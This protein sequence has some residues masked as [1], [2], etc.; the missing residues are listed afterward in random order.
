[1]PTKCIDQMP[2]PIAKAPVWLSETPGGI[3]HRPPTLGEHTD[4]IMVELGYGS[5]D[6]SAL[7]EQKVI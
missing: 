7:R 6:I 3:R 1:M 4:E 5:G 2:A